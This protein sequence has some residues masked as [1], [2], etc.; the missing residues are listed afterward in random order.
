MKKKAFITGIDGQ[1][2]SYLAEFL[3]AKGYKV[4]GMVRRVALEDPE[5]HLWRL[6]HLLDKIK[7]YPA[8]LESYPSIFNVIEKV[9]PDEC[10]HLAAQ[11]FVSYS[12]EDEFSTI[13]TNINGTHF[14]LSAIKEKAPK[15]KIY[16]AA[17]SEMFGQVRETPQTENTPF[18]PRSPYGISKVAGFDLTRNYREAYGLF[19]LSGILFNHES[20]RRGFEFVTRKISYG[21]AEIKL[22]LSKKL[23]VGNI[24]AKRDWGFAGDYVRAMW[25][26]LQQDRPDDYVIATG[27]THS[28]KEFLELAFGH[29]GLDWKKFVVIDKTFYRP[30]EVHL[31]K[32]DYSKARRKF[33]WRPSVKFKDLVKMMVDHDLLRLKNKGADI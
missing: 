32:G 15:C 31:L 23:A 8:S 21:V 9:K 30:S 24:Y 17:S 2:G 12:F 26:M 5:H 20:P 4:Y 22:G 14:V 33:G 28:V 18:H 16:F 10:Y 11:S 1:D 13:N 25:M 29:V 3:L 6:R 27:E 19:A 7:L